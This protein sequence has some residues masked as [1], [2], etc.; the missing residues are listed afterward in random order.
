MLGAMIGDI[1]GSPYEFDDTNIK[2]TDFEIFTALSKPTDDTV[3]TAAVAQGIINGYGDSVKTQHQVIASMQELGRKFP[4]AG[5]GDFFKKWLCRERPTPYNS[6]GNGSAMRISSVAWLYDTLEEV[7]YFAESATIV[8]HNHP[9]GV[10]GAKAV[11]SAIFMARKGYSKEEIKEYITKKYRYNLNMT[12]DEIRPDYKHIET[13]EETVPQAFA[14]FLEGNDFEEVIRLA[15]SLGGDCD[16]LTAIAGSLAEGM[17]PIPDE[18]RDKAM[19]LL[20][21]EI[22]DIYNKFNTFRAENNL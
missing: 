1:V 11:A 6:F 18:I 21:A 19:S 16:T 9:E 3:M 5:Y 4:D 22:I 12:C 7:E 10:K 8:T 17:Y 15:V 2:T 14:A 13:C 20:P